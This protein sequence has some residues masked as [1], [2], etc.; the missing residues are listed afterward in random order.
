MSYLQADIPIFK[1]WVRA[2]FLFDHQHG[3]GQLVRGICFGLVA[4]PGEALGFHVLF[5]NGGCFYG[6]PIHALCHKEDAPDRELAHLE[7]WDCFEREFSVHAFDLLKGLQVDVFL[8]IGIFRGEYLFTV[9]WIGSGFSSMPDERKQHH[10]IALD[11]GNFAVMPNNR[12]R[13]YEASFAP[14]PFEEPPG[15]KVNTRLYSAESVVRT[16]GDGE[17]FYGTKA[18]AQEKSDGR[19]EGVQR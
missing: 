2:E 7:L 17:F 18:D 16:T 15:W 3:S 19:A 4:R 9:D 10:L 11:D 14:E 5:E 12:L 13:W 6:L 1:T 8:P